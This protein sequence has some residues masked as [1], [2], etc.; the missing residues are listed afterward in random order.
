MVIRKAE[1]K[2]IRDIVR[3]LAQVSKIHHELRPDLFLPNTVKYNEEQLEAL[4][5]NE[6]YY[7]AVA[8][9]GKVVGYIITIIQKTESE[10]LTPIKT[11]YIDDLCVDEDVR[12][13]AIGKKLYEHSVEIAKS[14]DCYN[15]TLNVWA[16]NDALDFYESLNLKIQKIGMEYIL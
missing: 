2:D 15:I 9:N 12:G 6:Q 10:L 1:K 3:L 11:L 14:L 16:S 5:S 8:D 4:L 7:I 13:Q